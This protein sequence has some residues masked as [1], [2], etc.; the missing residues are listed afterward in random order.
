MVAVPFVPLKSLSSVLTATYYGVKR[1]LCTLT[2]Y[3]RIALGAWLATW[4]STPIALWTKGE[5]IFPYWV[6]LG[7]LTQVVLTVGILVRVWTP[8]QLASIVGKI[9][10]GAWA[11][12]VVGVHTGWPFGH[13]AYSDVLQPQLGRVPLLIPFAWLM[14]LPPAWAVAAAI[15][16][17]DRSEGA[18]RLSNPLTMAV[19]AGVAFTAWDTFLDPQMVARGLWRW[20]TPGEYLGIPLLNFAGWWFAATLLTAVVRPRD[21][22]R[23][24]LLLVYTLTCIL[25]AIGLGIFWGQPVAALCGTIT[26]GSF[27]LTAWIRESSRWKYSS[28]P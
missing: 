27:A 17:C 1:G 14:M 28:G 23:M 12:E 21:I 13:Y 6:S 3:E 10:I 18:R 16:S 20:A 25:Q 19:L 24:P 2:R 26:M 5:H 15:L 7:V 9:L 11:I 8:L 22:P 4:I